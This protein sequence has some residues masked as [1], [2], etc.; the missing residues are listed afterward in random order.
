MIYGFQAVVVSR[1]QLHR[2]RAKAQRDLRRFAKLDPHGFL[3][4]I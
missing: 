3:E 1:W 4:T 2:S